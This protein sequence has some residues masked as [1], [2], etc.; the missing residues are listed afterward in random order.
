MT[1]GHQNEEMSDE[2]QGRVEINELPQKEEEL[3]TDEAKEVKGGGG[4]SGGVI[5][6]RKQIGEEIPQ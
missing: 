6:S 3:K 1:V 2:K 4:L 5:A